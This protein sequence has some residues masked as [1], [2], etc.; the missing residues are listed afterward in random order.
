M[1]L[2]L[3][4]KRYMKLTAYVH[5]ENNNTQPDQR[6]SN[7]DRLL[8]VRSLINMANTDFLRRFL[9]GRDISVDK[10]MVPLKGRNCIMQHMP[11]GHESVMWCGGDSDTGDIVQCDVYSGRK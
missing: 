10:P 4:L 1:N 6:N 5:T 2:V 7:G 3:S 11:M 9:P 8:K